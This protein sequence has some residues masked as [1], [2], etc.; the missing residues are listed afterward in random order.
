MAL[1]TIQE[2]HSA[3]N[4][5]LTGTIR[6]SFRPIFYSIFILPY[7]IVFFHEYHIENRNMHIRGTRN[8]GLLGPKS[9]FFWLGSGGCVIL[10]LG[11]YVTP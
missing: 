5:F 7:L 4:G 8:K 10:W 11:G 2:G 1:L 9:T 3:K 6:L